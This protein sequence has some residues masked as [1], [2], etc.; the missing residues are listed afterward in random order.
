MIQDALSILGNIER[1]EV[2]EKAV[3]K[4]DN[5][6]AAKAFREGAVRENVPLEEQ[7]KIAKKLVKDGDTS[8]QRVSKHF[9]DKKAARLEAERLEGGEKVR[10]SERSRGLKSIEDFSFELDGHLLSSLHKVYG[11]EGY[12]DYIPIKLKETMIHSLKTMLRILESGKAS[13]D[14]AGFIAIEGGK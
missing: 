4:F 3:Q 7:E 9:D 1:K 10:E 5:L 2:S 8:Y 12:T 13:K 11:L 14:V 6:P